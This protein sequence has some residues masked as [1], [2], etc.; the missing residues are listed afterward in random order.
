MKL[1]DVEEGVEYAIRQGSYGEVTRARMLSVETVKVGTYSGLRGRSMTTPR[2]MVRMVRLKGN[3]A[4]PIGVPE[5]GVI[6]EVFVRA[7]DV[8]ETWSKFEERER[9]FAEQVAAREAA[10]R[11][12]TVRFNDLVARAGSLSLGGELKRCEGGRRRSHLTIEMN[13]LD[14]LLTLAGLAPAKGLRDERKHL[15]QLG[16]PEGFNARISTL[17]LPPSGPPGTSPPRPG[18][19]EIEVTRGGEVVASTI[20][21][22]EW[23]NSEA[24]VVKAVELAKDVVAH[25]IAATTPSELRAR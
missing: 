25:G 24:W 20:V 8:M 13:A 2:H 9:V 7:R 3:Y 21:G 15:A 12:A 5:T 10:E 14:R 22:V 1:S 6:K 18:A 11:V 16:M 23:G 4:P 19:L 17:G